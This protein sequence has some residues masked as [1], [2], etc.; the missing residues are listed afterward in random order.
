MSTSFSIGQEIQYNSWNSFF[1]DYSITN[2]N[3]LRLELHI[4]SK[5]FYK[6]KDQYLI[7]P[8]IT[9]KSDKNSYY[10]LGVTNLSTFKEKIWINERNIW[11][12]FGFSLSKD[13]S[14]YFGRVRLE[15][16]WIN[17]KGISVNYNTRIRFRLGFEIFFNKKNMYGPKLVFFNEVF[18]ILKKGFPYYFNQNWTFIGIK[19]NI[20]RKYIFQSGFQR[21]SIVSNNKYIH[22][23]IWASTIF[24][25]L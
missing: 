25:K 9:L 13:K 3:S 5:D 7:R 21:N 10:S 8:S 2:S 11:Q 18:M 6:S 23:N 4:R 19:K 15:Q 12:Q 16:R 20:F 1:S 22:K 17:N 14:N 24:I